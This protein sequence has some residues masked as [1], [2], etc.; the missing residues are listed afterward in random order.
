M[1]GRALDL[2]RQRSESYSPRPSPDYLDH[3]SQRPRVNDGH[4]HRSQRQQTGRPRPSAVS[5]ARRTSLTEPDPTYEAAPSAEY[6]LPR[7]RPG[8]NSPH[9]HN[10]RVARGGTENTRFK[11][12]LEARKEAQN[13]ILN[14]YPLKVRYQD[15]LDEG[16]DED[17]VRRQFESLGMLP[18]AEQTG[19]AKPRDSAGPG[20]GIKAVNSTT[21]VR[22]QR[23]SSD[24]SPD[25]ITRDHRDRAVLDA[26]QPT[27]STTSTTT[28]TM[29]SNKTPANDNMATIM[30]L[31][32]KLEKQRALA[33]KGPSPTNSPASDA[34]LASTTA[35]K[36]QQSAAQAAAKA[37]KERLLQQKMEALQKSR[38]QRAQKAAAKIPPT[39]KPTADA[40][41]ATHTKTPVEPL[42]SK[43]VV[44]SVAKSTSP[45]IDLNVQPSRPAIPGLFLAGAPTTMAPTATASSIT[46][47]PVTQPN[48]T[49]PPQPVTSR[50]RPVAADFVD[51]S[52]SGTS[53]KRPFGQSRND[54][55]FIIDVSDE[56]DGEGEVDMDLD[57]PS[58]STN[59]TFQFRND[60]AT[61][62]TKSIRDLPPLSDFPARK[63]FTAPSSGLSTPPIQHGSK[64]LSKPEHLLRKELE[65]Q[66]MKKKIAEA[67]RR[68]KAKQTTSGMS[69]PLPI[70]TTDSPAR[71]ISGISAQRIETSLEIERLIGDTSRQVDEDVN[72]LVEARA[73]EQQTSEAVKQTEA[74]L[75]HLRRAK[76]AADLPLVDAKVE[77]DQKR[78]AEIREELA[79]IEASVQ[80]GIEEKRQLAEELDRLNREADEQLD[81][82][83]TK[84]RELEREEIR[85]TPGE[86]SLKS[87]E[88]HA[89]GLWQ[90]NLFPSN[91]LHIYSTRSS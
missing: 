88:L 44:A 10:H 49:D 17:V 62:S 70:R 47:E 76:L 45:I 16:I 50:K 75:R 35:I 23:Q 85:P 29:A 55:P 4:H 2:N 81:A 28:T 22:Q 15:F 13:A 51:S 6:A 42:A 78:L 38:E 32:E 65:I 20:G 34:P 21:M 60:R 79:R 11:S 90:G 58:S 57:E 80:K 56:S 12:V 53:F 31:R 86:S 48:S 91:S 69:T 63:L 25:Q 89:L 27:K 61:P 87:N 3:Q 41:D 36:G 18:V 43:P 19:T 83:K 37:E 8:S 5:V 7:D 66:E 14:L 82:Q 59:P 54:Q 33:A 39:S 9:N 64:S 67:E 46:A 84:L 77:Q 30:A 24:R 68:K 72:K 26:I 1:Y 40:A 71:T 73:A 74:E 52:S